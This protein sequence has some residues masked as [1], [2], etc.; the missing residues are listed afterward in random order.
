VLLMH[1]RIRQMGYRIISWVRPTT[2][3]NNRLDMYRVATKWNSLLDPIEFVRRGT[4]PRIDEMKPVHT[5]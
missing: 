5:A 1:L 2:A 3:V 4:E